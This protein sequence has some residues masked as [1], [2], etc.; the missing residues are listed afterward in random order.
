MYSVAWK[1]IPVCCS[2]NYVFQREARQGQWDLVDLSALN[3]HSPVDIW[4]S[5]DSLSAG[6]AVSVTRCEAVHLPTYI[7]LKR[8]G[9][10]AH[11][12]CHC[13]LS[14]HV[15]SVRAEGRVI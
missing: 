12:T 8:P 10:L 7:L 6:S 11:V 15:V 14:C 4:H 5:Q 9:V 1:M 2:G 13:L 3:G